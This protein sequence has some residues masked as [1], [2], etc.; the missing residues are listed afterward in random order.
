MSSLTL[1]PD[2]R[3]KLAEQ[4]SQNDTFIHSF[5]AANGMICAMAYVIIEQCAEAISVRVELGDSVNTVT[6]GR[7]QNTAELVA[8][9]LEEL[10]SGVS[11]ST[12]LGGNR[13]LLVKDTESVLRE[14]VRLGQG[15][16]CIPAGRVEQLG[17]LLQPSNSDPSRTVFRFELDSNGI[18]L[19]LLLPSD[20]ELAYELLSGCVQELIANYRYA[21]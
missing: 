18:T 11:P 15:S 3:S 21:A 14:A 20:R 1:S 17:L 5:H 10:A 13:S 9:L 8:L 19:P 6:L 2:A 7:H 4:V 16:Y 12:L